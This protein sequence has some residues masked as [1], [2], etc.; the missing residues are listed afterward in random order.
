MCETIWTIPMVQN[1]VEYTKCET[2][3]SVEMHATNM[4]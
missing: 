1:K 3:Q 2:I 4:L